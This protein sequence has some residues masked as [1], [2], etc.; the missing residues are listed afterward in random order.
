MVAIQQTITIYE[1]IDL[2]WVRAQVRENP[3]ITL[4]GL[5]ELIH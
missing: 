4:K 5:S 2:E 3:L 1:R